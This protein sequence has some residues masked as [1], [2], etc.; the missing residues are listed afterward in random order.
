M[1][2]KTLIAMG[3]FLSASA[4]HADSQFAFQTEIEPQVV[5]GKAVDSAWFSDV[6]QL[7]LHPGATQLGFTVGQIVFEDG[8]RRKFNSRLMVMSFDAKDEQTYQLNYKKFRTIEEA[9]KFNDDPLFELKTNN[10][11]PVKF[12]LAVLDKNGLQ[13]FRDYEREIAE[14]NKT[15]GQTVVAVGESATLVHS[16]AEVATGIKQQFA[17]MSREE[18]QAFMQWAMQNLK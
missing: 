5:N 4:V 10:G 2:K 14:F 11:E 9:N 7:Q 6:D 18:Q 15:T 8:K 17:G 1:F 3:L 13:G 16:N 12:K